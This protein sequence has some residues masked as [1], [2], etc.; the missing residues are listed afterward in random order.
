M[1]AKARARYIRMSPRKFR[2]I[3]PLVKGRNP[4]EAIAILASVNRRAS[5]YAVEL[6]KSAIANAKRANQDIDISSLYISRMVADGGPM[7]K[8]FRAASMGRASMIRKR[9]CHILIELDQ[10]PQKPAAKE[11]EAHAAK[12]AKTVKHETK[13]EAPAVREKAKKAGKKK[14]V[15]K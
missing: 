7:M 2:Q 3:I 15:S 8:R 1:I 10:V 4:E 6:L 12:A 14:A 11:K 5:E 13:A 9:T